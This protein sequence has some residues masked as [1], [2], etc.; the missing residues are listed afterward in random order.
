VAGDRAV[1]L[2]IELPTLAGSVPSGDGRAMI[3]PE[4]LHL[5]T[6]DDGN[7]TV[8]LST[9]LGATGR[10]RVEL[11][12]GETVLVQVASNAV[13]SFTPGTRVRLTPKPEPVLVIP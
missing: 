5:E 11:E 10:T 13:G 12:T 9:F 7:A 4:Q 3:R 2:G 8:V 1:V 6:A